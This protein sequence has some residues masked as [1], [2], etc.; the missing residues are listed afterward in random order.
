MNPFKNKAIITAI[1]W[2]VLFFSS[3][4]SFA[5]TASEPE[6]MVTWSTK[7]YVP[8][9]YMGKILPAKSGR[10]DVG[11]DLIDRNKIADLSGATITWFLNDNF[12]RSGIG[13]KNI[14]LNLNGEL[15]QIIRISVT[16]YADDEISHIFSIQPAEPEIVIDTKNPLL[17]S[18]NQIQLAAKKH[19]FGI[20]PFFFNIKGLDELIFKW[21]VDNKL[22]SGAAENP[23]LLSLDLGTPE[24]AAQ[25]TDLA[26]SASAAN[27]ND[28]FEFGSKTYN[29]SVR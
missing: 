18:F 19:V 15:N 8:S 25:E 9:D 4:L 16:D 12:I 21:R 20:R 7:N 29:F 17:L 11:F 1:L 3:Q 14:S 26:V 28:Q 2:I 13:L 24:G 5:Q 27:I 6:F 23:W 22:I 10:L